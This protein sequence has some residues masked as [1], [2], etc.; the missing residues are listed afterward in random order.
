MCGRATDCAL[1]HSELCVSV[2]ASIDCALS[3]NE[4]CVCARIDCALSHSQHVCVC[5]CWY[6][7]ALNH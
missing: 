6:G 1:S 4:L 3:H 2:C 7:I 5:V